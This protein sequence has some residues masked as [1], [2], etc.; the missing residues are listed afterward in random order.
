MDASPSLT[1]AL[2]EFGRA[3]VYRRVTL[4]G[5]SVAAIREL[6][7]A[8]V[9]ANRRKGLPRRLDQETAGNPFFIAELINHW[10]AKE[11]CRP[12]VGGRRACPRGVDV[13]ASVRAVTQRLGALERKPAGFSTSRPL[14]TRVHHDLLETV[15]EIPADTLLDSLDEAIRMGMIEET[16]EAVASFRFSHQLSQQ[17]LRR[18]DRDT[19]KTTSPPRGQALKG[20]RA[21]PSR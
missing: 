17:T 6:L 3:Q 4:S 1:S 13:P 10:T 7:T 21:E 8:W 19:T 2:A 18:S 11:A 9:A 15:S 20:Q 16:G 14:P 12:T 5:L